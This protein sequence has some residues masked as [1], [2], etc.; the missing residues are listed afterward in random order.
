MILSC[1][2]VGLATRRTTTCHSFELRAMTGVVMVRQTCRTAFLAC[3]AGDKV[4]FLQ[5]SSL[6]RLLAMTWQ[7]FVGSWDM[8]HAS[9]ASTWL[10]VY[11][12]CPPAPTVLEISAQKSSNVIIR[13]KITN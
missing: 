10:T 9:A 5:V 4:N 7:H 1:F 12:A 8:D 2:A 11:F 3:C 13:Y 6:Y